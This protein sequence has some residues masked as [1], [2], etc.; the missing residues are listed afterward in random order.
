[1]SQSYRFLTALIVS[2]GAFYLPAQNP[3]Y[4]QTNL[5]SDVPGMAART[6]SQLVNAWGIDR[7]PT[8]PWWVNSNGKGLSIV[9]DGNGNPFP[10]ATPIVVTI[11]TPG[12]TGTSTP[13]GI[14][15]NPTT[16]FQIAPGMQAFFL[17]ATEDGTI[18]GWNP[19]VDATHA[20]IK[21]NNNPTGAVYK[22]LT[23]GQNGGNVIYAA[24]FGNGTVDVFN[25]SFAGGPSAAFQDPLL[26]AGYAPFNVQNIGGSIY[27]TFAKKDPITNDDIPGPGNGYVDQFTPA[28]LLIRRLEHGPWM[29]GPWGLALAPGNFGRLSGKLLVGQFGS[30]QIAAF[31]P[32]TGKFFELMRSSH[33]NTPVSIDGLWGIG[34]G[35]GANA[36]PADVLFF[37]AGIQDEDH[38][39]F[40]TLR[41]KNGDEDD[42]DQGEN[43]NEN[44][45]RNHH[46]R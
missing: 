13:T 12:G 26:P 41:P 27:V 14:V 37:A 22:G 45:N 20:V 5:V 29:N 8:G 7:S 3:H 11:P 24:N 2:A 32:A 46:D 33:G 38:G 35:N 16:D 17:F 34:F 1:M 40:G 43:E 31:D 36:G 44:G 15:F 18:S 9:Y 30:G 4:V 25:S 6:D 21:V 10:M 42:D 39:L 23:L 19:M 28:G